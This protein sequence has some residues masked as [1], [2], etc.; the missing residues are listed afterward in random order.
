M[1]P[2][3]LDPDWFQVSVKVPVK[4]PLYC[5]DQLPERSTAAGAAVGVAV[6][7]LGTGVLVAGTFAVAVAAAAGGVPV[8]V[9]ALLQAASRP[10]SRIP[11]STAAV[12]FIEESSR[13]FGCA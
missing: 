8:V 12:R 11:V 10:T 13:W 3:T 7:V 1:L 9:G 4:T 6:T 2:V 5:P